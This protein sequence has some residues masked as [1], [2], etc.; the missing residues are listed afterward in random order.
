MIIG[1]TL[2]DGL[3]KIEVEGIRPYLRKTVLEKD[4][5][6]MKSGD[7]AENIYF[8]T[9]GMISCMGSTSEG[10]QLE[11]YAAGAHDVVGATALSG[12]KLSFHAKVQ[13]A[14]EAAVIE[15]KHF[16]RLLERFHRF[17][18]LFFLYLN[19][20]MIKIGQRVCCVRFHET[21]ARV[22]QW[23]ALVCEITQ[24]TQVD[25]TQQSIAD[26]IGTRRATVTMILGDLEERGIIQRNRGRICVLQPLALQS[27][28]CE[29]FRILRPQEL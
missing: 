8:P 7:P 22:S 3:M 15:G 18:E 12:N 20:M 21:S 9:A 11:I 28:S 6:L 23:L 27:L 5:I 19:T 10:E 13:I 25:C 14:G 2:L 29:C 26:A 17:R 24:K 4:A 16:F 1:N